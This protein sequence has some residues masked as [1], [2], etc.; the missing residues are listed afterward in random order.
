MPVID[1]VRLAFACF[2]RIPVR[3]ARWEGAGM[4]YLLA[5][6]PLVGLV[7][8]GLCAVVFLGACELGLAPF[9]RGVAVSCVPVALCGGLHLDG[10]A[11]VC[12]ALA[13]HASPEVRQKIMKDPHLGAFAVV[14]LVGCMLLFVAAASE[15]TGAHLPAFCASFVV[16][17]CLVATATLV[18]P[19]RPGQGMAA[20]LREQADAPLVRTVLALELTCVLVALLLCDGTA[21]LAGLVAAGVAYLWVRRVCVRELGGMSGDVAGFLLVVSE[22]AMQLAVVCVGKV[23]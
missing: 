13:S 15:L 11:D 6:L 20:G 12:D 3:R 14:G 7:V 16:S 23:A 4:R 18:W 1:A 5:A 17:R 22:L 21:A 10:L 9:A 2:S 8:A 19:P